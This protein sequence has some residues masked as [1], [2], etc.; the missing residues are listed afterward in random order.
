MR[1]PNSNLTT[2]DTVAAATGTACGMGLSSDLCVSLNTI[3]P[4]FM[5]QLIPSE[6][7]SAEA[8]TCAFPSI[9][10]ELQWMP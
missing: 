8:V 1:F 4:Q 9:L 5:P 2:I 3:D 6:L 10:I 7:V